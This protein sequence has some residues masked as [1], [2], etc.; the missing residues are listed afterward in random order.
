MLAPDA[1]TEIFFA[2]E[3]ALMNWRSEN[4]ELFTLIFVLFLVLVAA[5]YLYWHLIA[6]ERKIT[7]MRIERERARCEREAHK[8]NGRI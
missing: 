4:P 1:T 6:R 8:M 5:L 7:A 2:P 3:I